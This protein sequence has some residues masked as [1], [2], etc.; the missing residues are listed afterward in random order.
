MLNFFSKNPLLRTFILLNQPGIGSYT[1]DIYQKVRVLDSYK[2]KVKVCV[3][4]SS[5]LLI[6]I[7]L[8]IYLIPINIQG[9]SKHLHTGDDLM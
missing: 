7:S 5:V 8:M 4:C 3:E 1:F 6:M 2:L 9:N